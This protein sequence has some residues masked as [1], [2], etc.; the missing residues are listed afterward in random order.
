[1]DY[2]LKPFIFTFLP[3]FSFFVKQ[4][5]EDLSNNNNVVEI[6]NYVTFTK[7]DVVL[8]RDENNNFK[9]N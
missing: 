8:L 2:C 9:Q 4:L 5:C 1:M 6:K 3:L 7:Q